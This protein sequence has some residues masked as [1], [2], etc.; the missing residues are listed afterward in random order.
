VLFQGGIVA[1]NIHW[2]CNLDYSSEYC[3]P[4]YTF[5]RLDNRNA[6]IA[7]GWNFRWVCCGSLV[8]INHLMYVMSWPW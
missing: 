4:Q 1:I 7:K 2:D 3:K 5:R 6:H 8:F